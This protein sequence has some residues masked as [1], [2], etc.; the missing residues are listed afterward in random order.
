MITIQTEVLITTNAAVFSGMMGMRLGAS[1]K[2][3]LVIPGGRDM[4]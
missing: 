2:V 3:I 1:L 4:D